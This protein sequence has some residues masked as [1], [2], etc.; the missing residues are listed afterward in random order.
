MHKRN[1]TCKKERKKREKRRKEG[2]ENPSGRCTNC[3]RGALA[4]KG[5][6]LLRPT[7]S[8]PVN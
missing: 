6:I 2:K 4:R 3:W 1:I 5:H 8:G 7:F